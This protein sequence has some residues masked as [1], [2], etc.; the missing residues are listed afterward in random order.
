[1]ATVPFPDM[2]TISGACP[3]YPDGAKSVTPGADTFA[4]PVHIYVGGS[5][6]VAVRSANGA[7]AVTFVALPAGSMV[8][9]RVIGIDVAGTTATSLIA[10]Y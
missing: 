10:V 5:G 8:P 2:T 4:V 3:V 9:C 6:N 1:M 7:P